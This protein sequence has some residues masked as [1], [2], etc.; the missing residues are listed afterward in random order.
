MNITQTENTLVLASTQTSGTRYLHVIQ[1]VTLT[2]TTIIHEVFTDSSSTKTLPSD[3]Y[4][5]LT[6]FALPTTPGSHYYVIDD[7]I[8]S[9][10]DE[11]VTVEELMALNAVDNGIDRNDTDF[12]TVYELN[13]Y[14]VNLLKEKFQK[15][16][17][18]CGCTKNER[19]SIDPITMGLYL[20]EELNVYSMYYES[21]RIIEQLSRCSNGVNSSNCNCND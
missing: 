18:G 13:T 11:V 4:Y 15:V 17:C 7:V 16:I 1:Q 3:G 6:E 19:L 9:P 14:Y 20:I 5:I 8:Y 21:Q 12:F 2:A 10:T